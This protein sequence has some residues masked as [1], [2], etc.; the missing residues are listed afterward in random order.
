MTSVNHLDLLR[1]QT[2][3]RLDGSNK[4]KQNKQKMTNQYTLIHLITLEDSELNKQKLYPN[5][6][7]RVF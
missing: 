3:L 4:R 1:S 2:S 6:T 5:V 7:N